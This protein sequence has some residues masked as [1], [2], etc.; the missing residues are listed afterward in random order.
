[1][2][3]REKH[4]PFENL[5]LSGGGIWGLAYVGVAQVLKEHGIYSKI[6]RIAAVSSGAIFG[7]LMC[8]GYEPEDMLRILQETDFHSFED[9]PNLLRVFTKYGFFAG[10]AFLH[11]LQEQVAASPL[12]AGNP[13]LTFGELAEK[14]G[15]EFYAFATDLNTQTYQE[16]SQRWTPDLPIVQAVRASMS[17]PLIFKAWKFTGEDGLPNIYC[18]GGMMNNYPLPFFDEPPFVKPGTLANEETLGFLFMAPRAN[19]KRPDDGLAYGELHVY[20]KSLLES[21]IIGVISSIESPSNTERTVM[22]DVHATG[23]SPIHF[24]ISSEEVE[25]LVNAGRNSLE[26]YL[27]TYPLTRAAAARAT[28]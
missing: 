14:G 22:T 7:A 17:L 20:L 26:E 21:I 12:G 8:C 23:I 10:D 18:D 19:A 15:R 11:W 16:F 6:K 28:A 25:L 1:M 4:F 13:D 27:S 3:K 24:K 5:V 2:G 9:K